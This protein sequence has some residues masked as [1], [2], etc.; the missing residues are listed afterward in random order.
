MVTCQDRKLDRSLP[1]GRDESLRVVLIGHRQQ[2]RE[3]TTQVEQRIDDTAVTG[4]DDRVEDRD[5]LA[6]SGCPPKNQLSA[7]SL[8]GRRQF[9]TKLVSRFVMPWLMRSTSGAQNRSL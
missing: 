5:E 1:E 8:V 7:P 3:D 2:Q 6:A 4:N 9:S